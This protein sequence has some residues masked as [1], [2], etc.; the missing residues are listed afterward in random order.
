MMPGDEGPPHDNSGDQAGIGRKARG[1]HFQFVAPPK[2]SMVNSRR[3]PELPAGS[4]KKHQDPAVRAP[5]VGPSLWEAGGQNPLARKPSVFMMPMENSPPPCLVESDVVAPRA[6]TPAWNS[7]PRRRKCVA[8][9]PPC[10]AMDV[11]LRLARRPVGP[12]KQ[13]RVPSGRVGWRGVDRRGY[14]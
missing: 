2:I 12:Q 1:W 11:D 14:R 8:R 9:P 5:K 7:C 4:R 6:T 13:I 3:A 10:A